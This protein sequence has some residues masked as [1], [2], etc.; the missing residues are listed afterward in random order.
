MLSATTLWSGI[1][2]GADEPETGTVPVLKPKPS[3]G[4]SATTVLLP[5]G[6][7]PP[8][9]PSA[10]AGYNRRGWRQAYGRPYDP[11]RM[12]NPNLFGDADAYGR[13]LADAS[14]ARK[15]RE[16][17]PHAEGRISAT[18]PCH[19]LATRGD[20]LSLKRAKAPH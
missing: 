8:L 16:R 12:G 10:S 9:H 2:T 5:A 6:R 4:A 18:E 11:C 19:F 7:T 20:S 14:S 17:P 15:P 13:A 1:T 3:P